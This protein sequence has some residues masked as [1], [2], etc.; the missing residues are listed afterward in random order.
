MDGTVLDNQTLYRQLVSGL[1][2]LTVTRL[3]IAYPVHVLSQFLS[4]PCT[5]YAAVFR[6][7]RYIKGTLFHGLYF[8][9]HSSL[10]LQA[11]FDADWAGDPIDHR[12]TTGYC[13]FLG[14][15]LI[16]WRAKKQTFTARSSTEA[17][18][19]ALADTTAEL[20]SVC[21]FFEDLGAPQSSL[22]IF[23]V[24][25]AVLFKSPIMMCFMNAPN[26]LSLIVTLF[27]NVSLLMLFVS[28]LLEH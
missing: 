14:D 18:Y 24:I 19:R 21:W 27:G 15:T 4:A 2:Y 1:V 11:Y 5:H 9:A 3:D 6:I 26:T 23:F 25:T 10:S 22:L 17:E 13:L 7:L 8:S 12:S 16:S 28:L 20:I